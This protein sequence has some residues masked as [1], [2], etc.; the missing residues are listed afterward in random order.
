M[1]LDC[2][3]CTMRDLAC[4]DCVV[5]VLLG[6]PEVPAAITPT[7]RRPDR[8]SRDTRSALRLPLADDDEAVE[9]R[10]LR[11]LADAGLISDRHPLLRA[12]DGVP[13]RWA[14]AAS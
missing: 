11:V 10:A 8:W 9:Q 4:G 1:L 5:T 7:E 6:L 12:A 14:A 13:E 3:S 2:D